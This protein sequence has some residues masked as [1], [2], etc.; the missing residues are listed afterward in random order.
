MPD[1][2]I[3]AFVTT[4]ASGQCQLAGRP[5]LFVMTLASG[6]CQLAGMPLLFVM[7]LA[8]G[9]CQLAG[10]PFVVCDD[11]GERPASTGRYAHLDSVAVLMR[12]DREANASRSPVVE[13]C[14][15]ER[16][17]LQA[18]NIIVMSNKNTRRSDWSAISACRRQHTVSTLKSQLVSR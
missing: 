8:S 9:Q 6:Q 4:L 7:T 10:M 1:G 17:F 11:F 2:H 13:S 3:A 15:G 5:L 18:R 12:K 14:R 16:M